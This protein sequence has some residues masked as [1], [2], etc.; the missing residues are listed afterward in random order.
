MS[1]AA[2]W[3]IAPVGD[4]CLIVEFGQ[5]IAPAINET[6]RNFA[7]QMLDAPV[8]GIVDVVPAFTTVALH[9]RPECF[10]YEVLRQR[11]ENLLACG[12]RQR[13]GQTRTV[14]IPVCYGGEYG[15][16][17]NEVAAACG[18][19]PTQVIEHHLASAHQVYM[20]GFVPGLAYIGGLDAKLTVPRR[21]TPRTSV[22]A[23]SIAIASDQTCIYP[24]ES[25]G[26]WNL[27]G[28][29]RL[30]LFDASLE[31]PCLL[32]PGDRVRFVP[33]SPEA[34]GGAQ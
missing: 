27:I 22:P 34:F 4:R 10:T 19:T 7:A 26:G 30:R 6:V 5:S 16:D 24:L 29:T 8:P 28:R 21:S 9:Y 18:M 20:L 3:T 32:Q 25:P 1:M 17:L 11:I 13:Q 33:I 2:N 12:I 31:S 14:E 15:I 23:G